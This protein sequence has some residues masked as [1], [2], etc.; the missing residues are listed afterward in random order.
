MQSHVN[1]N[2]ILSVAASQCASSNYRG[3]RRPDKAEEAPFRC[4]SEYLF[5]LFSWSKYVYLLDAS[6]LSSN[7]WGHLLCYEI[8]VQRR[9]ATS[10]AWHNKV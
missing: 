2:R 8:P 6:S 7:G 10:T 3:R 4:C 5:Y 1:G 9:P